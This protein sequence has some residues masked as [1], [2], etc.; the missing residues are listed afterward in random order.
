M[1]T[2][3]G[4]V[5][6][7]DDPD[8]PTAV[9]LQRAGARLSLVGAGTRGVTPPGGPHHSGGPVSIHGD[10]P[11]GPDGDIGGGVGAARMGARLEEL[12]AAL[13]RCVAANDAAPDLEKVEQADFLINRGLAAELAAAADAKVADARAHVRRAQMELEVRGDGI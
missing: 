13:L 5:D 12:R 8:E 11:S 3:R 6:V 10:H 2:A 9:D 1:L 4:D 7:W